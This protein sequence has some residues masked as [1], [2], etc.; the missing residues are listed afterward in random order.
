MASKPNSQSD[1]STTPTG[2]PDENERRAQ[3]CR[4]NAA[5]C[6]RVA[7]ISPD[8]TLRKFYA[9]LSVEWEKEAAK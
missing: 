2:T 3:D 6:K 1:H 8:E 5:Y 7:S 9:T 4:A